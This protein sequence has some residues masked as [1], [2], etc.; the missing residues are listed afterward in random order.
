MLRYVQGTQETDIS[1]S[2]LHPDLGWEMASLQGFVRI[3]IE[4]GSDISRPGSLQQVI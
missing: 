3:L 1:I 4:I 2:A